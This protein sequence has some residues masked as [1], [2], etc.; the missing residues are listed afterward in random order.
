MLTCFKLP[1]SCFHCM[2]LKM[3]LVS[4]LKCYCSLL[5]NEFS[6]LRTGSVLR[7][8]KNIPQRSFMP[9]CIHHVWNSFSLNSQEHWKHG[10][11][12]LN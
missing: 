1:L 4:S 2:I 5:P 3:S 10:C 12:D 7:Q 9:H 11:Q 8:A 6:G